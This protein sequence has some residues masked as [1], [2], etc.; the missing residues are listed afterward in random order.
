[1]KIH[2]IAY[3]SVIALVFS[4][5]IFSSAFADGTNVVD[6]V[7]IRVPVSCTMEGTGMNSHNAEIANGQ[8]NSNIGESTLKAY[9]NDNNGFIIYAIGYTDNTDGKNVLTS[10]TLGSTH[11][12]ITG[13]AIAPV[14]NVDNS[15]WAMK[16][17][18]VSSPTPTYPITIQNSFDSFHTV[19]D[20]YTAVAKRTGGTDVGTQAEGTTLKTTYQ[21][22]ISKTQ[23]AGTYTGQVKY[24]LLHPHSIPVPY[25]TMLDTGQVVSAKMKSLAAG[26]T[27]AYNDKTSDIK[28]I[29]MA[30]SLPNGF[31]ATDANTVSTID[32]ENPIYIFFDNANEAG[33][34]YFYAGKY[35][36][37]MNPDS[38]HLFRSNL[39]LSDI[40]GLENW[41][42]SNVTT[43]LA[44]FA[45]DVSL[46]NVDALANWDTHNVENLRFLFGFNTQVINDGY[47]PQ[48][49]DISGL[50]NWNT[51][52]VTNMQSLFQYQQSL[53]SLHSLEF[54]DVSSVED[55]NYMFAYATS[56]TD[57]S[58]LTNWDVSSVTSMGAL[59]ENTYLLTDFSPLADWNVLSVE[60]MHY[61]FGMSKG[62][63]KTGDPIIDL[64]P[65][66]DWNVSNATNMATMFQNINIASFLPLSGW[67][68][69][70][71][72]DF[73]NMFSQTYESTVTSTLA[74]L[75]GWNVSSA[76][77][78][79]C[80]FYN[81]A[82]LTD[83][84]AI[85]GWDIRNVIPDTSGNESTN[86]GFNK[87][88][89]NS[90]VHPTFTLRPGTWNSN[91][92]FIPSS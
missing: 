73:N 30:D 24:T 48:L 46:T 7:N 17:S 37:I 38:A 86:T 60:D 65:L 2:K 31:V 3:L 8:Y 47:I 68:V 32:S 12:I 92:T 74:G 64:S 21:A 6:K 61:V 13:T 71:V 33:I 28:A 72:Q 66:A 20:E 44:M 15:Q 25:S 5:A 19:P 34:M 57:I 75:E 10:S 39:A 43:M 87:M 69:G 70:K 76:T 53:A 63:S 11:D 62:K 4:M 79:A 54:W 1:M 80:M 9:C 78:M 90:P 49:T 88:F 77:N 58:A 14:G 35:R 26:T 55:M 40:S 16:L 81:F 22:Y 29:R 89:F 67:D 59:F 91:G 83:A 82:G 42:S 41:D 36:V 85:N 23:S 56:L 18:T 51:S 27:K 84:S 50:M 45:D 52:N